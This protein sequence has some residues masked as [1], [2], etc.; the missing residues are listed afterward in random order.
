MASLD[1]LIMPSAVAPS[2]LT[3][4]QALLNP[5]I[6]FNQTIRAIKK[7]A[8]AAKKHEFRIIVADNTGWAR[9]IESVIHKSDLGSKMIT[10]L[11]VP[12]PT[13]EEIARGKGAAETACL[14]YALNSLEL[15][16]SSLVAKVNA[17]YFVTNGMFLVANLSDSFQFAAWPRPKLDSVDTTFFLGSAGFLETIFPYVYKETD[18][19]AEKFVE[20]LYADFSL[21]I[22]R[23]DFERLA[24]APAIHGQSGTT[25]SVASPFNEARLVSILVRARFRIREILPFIKPN[26]QRSRNKK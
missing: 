15:E 8:K 12:S 5:E 7:W 16:D 21:R 4:Y 20:N 14:M 11:D 18:D 9:R 17:R 24:Y 23:C 19:L 3:P 13:S 10:V 25:A 26:Y 22:T 2:P 6:R 1:Y